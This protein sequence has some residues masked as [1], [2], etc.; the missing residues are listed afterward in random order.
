M[1]LVITAKTHI[2]QVTEV[3]SENSF[4][5]LSYGVP[6]LSP[7]AV[8]AA[9]TTAFDYTKERSKMLNSNTDNRHTRLPPTLSR[10][11]EASA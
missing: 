10:L 2:F 8:L 7:L 1:T 6:Y 5:N 3:S 4:P 11:L 9:A